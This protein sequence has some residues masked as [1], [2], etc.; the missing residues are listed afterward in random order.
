MD[1]QGTGGKEREWGEREG[2]TGRDLCLKCAKWKTHSRNIR[3]RH[4]GTRCLGKRIIIAQFKIDF[5]LSE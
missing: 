1:D 4:L 3:R 5:K 2:Q